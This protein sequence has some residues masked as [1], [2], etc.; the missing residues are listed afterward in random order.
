[1]KLYTNHIPEC[2]MMTIEEEKILGLRE[3]IKLTIQHLLIANTKGIIIR[4]MGI[5]TTGKYQ[6]DTLDTVMMD[7]KK[8]YSGF[9]NRMVLEDLVAEVMIGLRFTNHGVVALKEGRVFTKSL[10]QLIVTSTFITWIRGIESTINTASPSRCKT[11][12][13]TVI[14][15]LT[16][17][18]NKYLKVDL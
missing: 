2:I 12:T 3:W 4:E 14:I 13:G 11:I 1:M 5:I 18:R 9:Q 16:T 17:I 15:H 7:P 8:G 10:V 6:K